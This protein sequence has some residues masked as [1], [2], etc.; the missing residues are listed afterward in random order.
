MAVAQA[1]EMYARETV[2]PKEKAAAGGSVVRRATFVST[3]S[4]V[5][6][7]FLSRRLLLPHRRP[8]VRSASF[9]GMNRA[10][11]VLIIGRVVRQARNAV[12]P[13]GAKGRASHDARNESRVALF[14]IGGIG[15][16]SGLSCAGRG[17]R[18]GLGPSGYYGGV[19][20]ARHKVVAV[21]RSTNQKV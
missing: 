17:Q 5:R 14:V 8:R 11:S 1:V 13:V 21:Q 10:K 9:Q 2:V 6:S 7:V 16:F 19:S 4:V 3:G 12:D 20:A 15:P 18:K